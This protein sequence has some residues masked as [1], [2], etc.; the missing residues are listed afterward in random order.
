MKWCFIWIFV[1][2][3]NVKWFGWFGIIGW[4]V[5]LIKKCV[6]YFW[7]II[8]IFCSILKCLRCFVLY[9]IVVRI[10][11]WV[12]YCVDLFIIIWCFFVLWLKCSRKKCRLV[13]LIIFGFVVYIGIM[14]FMR[15]GYVVCWMWWFNWKF[16]YSVVSKE[17]F[18][19]C[20]LR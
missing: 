5:K 15:M 12:R 1:C 17:W 7:F 11:I 6:C 8:W 3:L 4:K 9:L 18:N 19:V 13:V 10:L 16:M 14:V 2:C 20:V